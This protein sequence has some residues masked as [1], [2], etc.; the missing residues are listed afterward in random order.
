MKAPIAEGII[1][2][3]VTPIDDEERVDEPAMRRV[4]RHV[5]DGG[6]HGI[7][8][9][10]TTGESTSL[11]EEEWKR[12]IKIILDEVGGRVPVLGGV[13]APGTGLAIRR[14]HEAERLNVAG[15]VASL[16]FYFK[17]TDGE[18]VDHYRALAQASSIPLYAYNIGLTK[19]EFGA[20]VVSELVPLDAFVGLKDST[21]NFTVFQKLV[22]RFASDSF[23]MF[24]GNETMLSHSL[25]IGGSGGVNGLANL[26]PGLC[27]AIFN[28]CKSRQYEEAYRL[29]RKL[30]LLQDIGR[31]TP[32]SLVGQKYALSLLGL[33]SERVTKP[34]RPLTR[35]HRAFIKAKLQ[36]LGIL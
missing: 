18:I 34:L 23:C 5:L 25:F 6:V 14:L 27:V 2:P 21:S 11:T 33:C 8:A 16:P 9:M 10:G 29:Q 13:L 30:T 4:V 24:Q 22:A 31:L 20:E 35:E 19:M 3:I 1:V 15:V 12:G 32:T 17:L 36:E 26:V 7:M 28:A